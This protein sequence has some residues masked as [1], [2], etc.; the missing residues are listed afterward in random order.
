MRF[1]FCRDHLV[2]QITLTFNTEG[3]QKPLLP[4]SP[5]GSERSEAVVGSRSKFTLHLHVLHE[6]DFQFITNEIINNQHLR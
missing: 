1:L 6:C 4:D 2:P 5:I 3:H